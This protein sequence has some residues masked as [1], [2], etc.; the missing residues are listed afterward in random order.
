MCAVLLNAKYLESLFFFR[1][2]STAANIWVIKKWF[3]HQYLHTFSYLLIVSR[4]LTLVAQSQV[5]K[6]EGRKV[7][8]QVSIWW[9]LRMVDPQVTIGFKFQV[10][11]SWN[12]LDD[13]GVAPILGFGNL[14]VMYHI[15]SY[16][17]W[18]QSNVKN[19]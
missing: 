19:C 18:N 9:F 6:I 8:P 14:H 1:C 5:L 3:N 15:N 2:S 17:G 13:V 10:K 4:G 12:D 16:Q 7:D 11:W